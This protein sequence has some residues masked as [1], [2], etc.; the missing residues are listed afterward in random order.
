MTNAVMTTQELR[1]TRQTST[2]DVHVGLTT[3]SGFAL[4][5]RIATMLSSSTMVPEQYRSMIQVKTGK[6]GFGNT[7]YEPRENPNGIANSI[8]AVNMA[9]RLGADP[10]MVMQNLYIIE[11]R[12]SWSSQFVIASIN[13]S[14]KYSSLRFEME[15]R[16]E[17][18]VKYTKRVWEWNANKG[19]NLPKDVQET[20]KVRDLVCKAWAIEK[21]TGERLESSEITMKM[22]ISEGWYQKNGS[23][24][25]TMPEQML[26]YRAAAFF[27]RIYAPELLMG[28]KTQEEEIDSI[29]DVTPKP[30]EETPTIN[31]SDLRKSVTKDAEPQPA[32]EAEV[33]TKVEAPEEPTPVAQETKAPAVSVADS[34][35]L[36]TKY[37]KEMNALKSVDGVKNKLS[38]VTAD[39]NLTV[40]HKQYLEAHAKQC[41]SQLTQP[42]PIKSG[43][44]RDGHIRIFQNVQSLEALKT[45]GGVFAK[46]KPNMM[47]EDQN[48]A[49]TEYAMRHKI[50]SQ[51]DLNLDELDESDVIKKIIN[52]IQNAKNIDDLNAIMAEPYTRDFMGTFEIDQAYENRMIELGE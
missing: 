42:D 50:L 40:C 43:V 23:K 30:A 34:T 9:N 38:Q 33:E 51:A 46:D 48:A 32:E 36:R 39:N 10:L 49:A 31:S 2:A 52:S 6:D 16:G 12:P 13:A 47:V 24:W 7:T 26:R 29:I 44:K 3:T 5:Q 45:A 15:D 1:Q 14:G 4:I 8:V 35:K 17:I 21:E 27:G 22:A 11:G 41:I 37:I 20:V 28:I 25:Q 18:E 19:K